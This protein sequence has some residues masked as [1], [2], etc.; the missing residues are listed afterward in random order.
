M[1]KLSVLLLAVFSFSAA[2]HAQS[3]NSKP[4]CQTHPSLCTELLNPYDYEGNYTGHDEP[5]VL[6]Y[7]EKSGSGNSSVYFITL[8]QDPPVL[9]DQTGTAGTFNFQLH[10]A[11]WFGMAMCDTEGFP[12]FTKVCEP[13]SDENIFDD[14]SPS[15]SNWIGRHPG[16]AFMEMQF[17][18]PGWVLWPAG[19]SCDPLQWCAALNIDSVA[20]SL[21][22]LNNTAC[23]NSVGDEPVNFAF[24]TQSGVPVGPPDPLNATLATFTPD[25]AK[26]L[27]M[28]SGDTLRVVLIDTPDG[29]RVDI[30][31]LTTGEHGSMTASIANGFGHVRFEPTT[32]TC[33]AE[34]YAF[35]P[36]YAT[37]S[38]HTRVSWAAH[39][40]N[41]AFAD[42]LGHFEY[43]DGITDANLHV[44]CPSTGGDPSGASDIDDNY[45][46]GPAASSRIQI[47][48]CF[49]LFS[50]GGLGDLDFDGVPYG[51]NWPGTLRN[52]ERDSRLHSTPVRFTSPLFF[53]KAGDD[54]AY[55]DT[56]KN[57]NRV[58][59]EVNLPRIELATNP[60]CDRA[61][62]LNC[63]NPPPGADF[64]PFYTTTES[65]RFEACAWQLG[66]PHIPETL[67]KF[68]GTSTAEYGSLLLLTYASPLDPGFIER[69]NNFRQV[70]LKN[71][72]KS[73]RGDEGDD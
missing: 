33:H 35:H 48:G 14:P 18:P 22:Q 32:T 70:L 42:E 15:S 8:P 44:T 45:C 3:Y 2:A 10:P 52:K 47:G 36:Q 68:G 4:F 6:F 55:R 46:F 59:F 67:N 9:P 56:P 50:P 73:T 38:E 39:S 57:Y 19:N 64:Y 51:N 11:F 17:Y 20:D 65:E 26:M 21:A 12:N 66:G 49:G 69:F 23:L 43:C 34:P 58:A 7:S 5:S 24:I 13:D 27:F 1:R 31:D 62:G 28:N 29:F 37:S 71:P 60:P 25:G 53:P 63:V 40:Y 41:V 72:C 54:G 16:T 61:T 30:L